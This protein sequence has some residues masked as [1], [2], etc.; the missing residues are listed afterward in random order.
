MR[1]GFKQMASTHTDSKATEPIQNTSMR[2]ACCTMR[3][4]HRSSRS[5]ETARA[6]AMK[7]GG[8]ERRA[9]S[10]AYCTSHTKRGVYLLLV[11]VV[12]VMELTLVN[13]SRVSLSVG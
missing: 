4:A 7:E 11:V 2:H 13:G 8:Q 6:E 5:K 12:I 1:L 3:R 9:R 10:H